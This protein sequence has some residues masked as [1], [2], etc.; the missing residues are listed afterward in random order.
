M[1]V[2]ISGFTFLKNAV[3]LDYPAVES[4]KSILPIVDE[5]IVNI[6]PCEDDTV[7]LIKSIDDPKIKIIYSQ[8]NPNIKTGGYIYAQQTNIA[9]F[10]CTGKWAFYLQS[11]EVVDED[12]LP[13]LVELMKRYENDDRIEGLALNE[14]TFWGDYNTIINVYP[15]RYSRRCWI[16]K[17]HKFVLSRGDASGFTV[18]PKYKEKGRKIRVLDTGAN[19]YHYSFV[20]TMK[21]LAE[22]YRQ[23]FKYWSDQFQNEQITDITKSIYDSWFPRSFVGPYQG[24]HPSVMRERILRHDVKVDL[25][26]PLWRT[27]LTLQDRKRLLQTTII[28][29]FGDRFIGRN[30]YK[31]VNV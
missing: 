23:V 21:K 29:L 28:K 20:K 13:R 16:V 25:N 27:K 11:D 9:L 19:I 18:H 26:S 30:S 10:N 5:F 3:L 8:W 2:R 12:D 7:D 22:K 31:L 24:K 6:G 14:L 17:P 4:I 15:W 1:S